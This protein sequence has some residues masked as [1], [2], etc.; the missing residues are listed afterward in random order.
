GILVSLAVTIAQSGPTARTMAARR[1]RLVFVASERRLIV[2][3]FACLVGLARGVLELAAI[4]RIEDAPVQGRP[5]DHVDPVAIRQSRP[6]IGLLRRVLPP[7]ARHVDRRDFPAD[8]AA[9]DELVPAVFAVFVLDRRVVGRH[10][11]AIAQ[12]S[13]ASC[14]RVVLRPL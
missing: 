5:V 10:D 3:L 6:T 13:E 11:R 1:R 4:L 8:I 9:V 7:W 2:L 14:S 12:I